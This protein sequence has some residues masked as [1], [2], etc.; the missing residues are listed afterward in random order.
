MFT[1]Q[2]AWQGLMTGKLL[3]SCMPDIDDQ[4]LYLRVSGSAHYTTESGK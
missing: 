2:R 1:A 4:M 3:H